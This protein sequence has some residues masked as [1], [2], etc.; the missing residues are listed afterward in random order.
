MK[1]QHIQQELL[2]STRTTLAKK[3][4]VETSGSNKG[5]TTVEKF[6]EACWN[7]LLNE[8]FPELMPY[9]QSEPTKIFIW[10]IHAGKSY[11]LVDLADSP[12]VTE[13]VFSIDPRLFF[14]E[15]NLS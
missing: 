1:K 2:I 14:P 6:E 12:G 10:G 5:A 9:N 8:M 7:G 3:V 11:L 15:V 4:L 13:S